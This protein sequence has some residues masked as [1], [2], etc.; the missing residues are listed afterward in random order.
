MI[1]GGWIQV[2]SFF[3]KSR[4]PVIMTIRTGTAQMMAPQ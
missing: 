2:A 1:V 3:S 4:I